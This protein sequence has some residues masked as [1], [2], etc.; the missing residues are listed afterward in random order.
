MSQTDI[1]AMKAVLTRIEGRNDTRR[2]TIQFHGEPDENYA[3]FKDAA[4]FE[5]SLGEESSELR[6]LTQMLG[7]K[8]RVSLNANKPSGGR[9]TT[10]AQIWTVLDS[11]YGDNA[12]GDRAAS[13]LEKLRQGKTPLAE[14]NY[15]FET[16]CAQ[17]GVTGSL[18][19]RLYRDKVVPGIGDRLRT[20]GISDFQEMKERAS[21]VAQDAERDYKRQNAQFEKKG[22]GRDGKGRFKAMDADATN[23][24]QRDLVCYNCNKK[25]HI[26]Y[27]CSE[28]KRAGRG[29]RGPRKKKTEEDEMSF[30]RMSGARNPEQGK[31]PDRPQ[32][33]SGTIEELEDFE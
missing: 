24:D 18:R 27:N 29:P 3:E 7:I 16:L 10:A 15:K 8:P 6:T 4:E 33:T 21:I 25:G 31:G 9:F 12:R 5:L 14:F 30:N 1:D 11:T 19:A 20:A 13:E 28:P 26:S 2:P 23:L 22:K 17:A 32:P